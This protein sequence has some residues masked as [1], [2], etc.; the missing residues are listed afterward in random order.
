MGWIILAVFAALALWLLATYNTLVAL[1]QRVRQSGADIDVQLRQ[2]LDL[3]PNLVET[4]KGYAAHERGVFDA[5]TQAR[6][7]ALGAPAGPARAAAEARLDASIGRLFAVAEA[8]PELKANETFAELQAQLADVE[9]RVAAAR[10]F[11]NAAAA[12]FNAAIES[13]PAVLFAGALGFAAMEFVAF[14][15]RERAE[16]RVAPQ[17]RF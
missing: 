16:M 17:V 3:I 1:R 10:R 7:S 12:E 13:L 14:E 4:V 9:S 8:Y 15:E 2:R 11:R 6:A 5:V